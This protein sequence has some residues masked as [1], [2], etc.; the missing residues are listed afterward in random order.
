MCAFGGLD[1]GGVGGFSRHRIQSTG[2]VAN[3]L[4]GHIGSLGQLQFNSRDQ[5][6]L[7]YSSFTSMFAGDFRAVIMYHFFKTP[8][9][10]V[11]EVPRIRHT[12]V[13][14]QII[15]ENLVVLVVIN[16]FTT[17]F[18]QVQ[19]THAHLL[20]T[21]IGLPALYLALVVRFIFS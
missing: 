8:T 9:V 7:L 20:L 16:S 6:L 4:V 2:A 5:I 1:R 11:H 13:I 21:V 19:T 10:V 3:L 17:V 18:A 14:R 12:D 15:R